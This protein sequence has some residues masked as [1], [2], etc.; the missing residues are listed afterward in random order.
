MAN[1]YEGTMMVSM[2]DIPDDDIAQAIAFL[3]MLDEDDEWV[4]VE[5]TDL[6]DELKPRK[7]GR[8]PKTPRTSGEFTGPV[9]SLP[10]PAS[11]ASVD[12]TSTPH[13]KSQPSQASA[14]PTK[15]SPPRTTPSKAT[16]LKALPTVRDH[17]TD[18]LG[19]EGD[20]YVARDFDD[21][22][23]KKVDNLGYLQGEREYKIRTFILPGRGEKLFMLATECARCL[24]YRDSY[25][26]F[27]KN[28][29]L[30]KIIANVK[31][32][33]ELV[34]R[35][36]LPY[37]YR[38]RQIAIVTARSMF[39]QFGSRVIKDGRRVRDDYWEAKAIKQGFTEQD[40]AGEKRPGAAKAREA[41]Q[42]DQLHARQLSAYGDVVYSNGPGFGSMAHPA[43]PPGMVLSSFEN[44]YEPKYRDIQ[45]PRQE[46]AGPPYMDVTRTVPEPEMASQVTHAAE[47]SRSVNQQG[48]YRRNIINEYWRRPHEPP[49]ST[50][51]PPEGDGT[52]TARDNP[53]SSPQLDPATQSTQ[54]QPPQSSMNP[55]SFPHQTSSQQPPVRQSS[56]GAGY[57]RDG[58]QFT[59]QHA[60][61]PRSSSN[62]SITQ[63][64]SQPQ[65]MQLPAGLYSPHG[66][67]QQ[68]QQP[69][70]G[71]PPPQPH[72]SPSLHRM[73]TPQFSPAMGHG[74][75]PSPLGNQHPSQSPHPQQMQP[76]QMPMMHHQGSSG[77]IGGQQLF[78]PGAGLQAMG[79]AGYPGMMNRAMYGM[80]AQNQFMQQAQQPGQGWPGQQGGQ[81]QQWNQGYP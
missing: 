19:P 70:W 36:I 34:N 53:F 55:P 37:S 78:G 50:P 58:S 81:G 47:Y 80:G 23:E 22:G 2:D 46:L 63:T 14:Q 42:Q 21:A 52:A 61:F 18:Q 29:S 3:S 62:L 38:S 8:P 39:R 1:T 65:S 28:R 59:P 15:A 51:P 12:V 41:A 4:W 10:T 76:P 13:V 67:G 54:Q 72:Q 68:Q 27:N 69:N 17:T 32:K 44:P 57:P 30:F 31:E 45:R 11:Q 79:A 20:E 56:I 75:I 16:P 9:D 5:L 40:P 33:E 35:D 6:L 66:V 49:V 7:R 24:Q 60:Q 71:G 73:S 48:Q 64:A 43:L 25:L 77:Q 26:L 74:Q